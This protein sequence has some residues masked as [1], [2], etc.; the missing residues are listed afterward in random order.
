M[1]CRRYS[2]DDRDYSSFGC[3]RAVCHVREPLCQACI[4]ACQASGIPR[5]S[6][7]WLGR[8]KSLQILRVNL[9]E[10][11]YRIPAQTGQACRVNYLVEK[12]GKSMDDAEIFRP[13]RRWLA[14]CL[15][16]DGAFADS[17]HAIQ[18]ILD[19]AAKREWKQNP[20]GMR[21]I[22]EVFEPGQ[23]PNKS[24]LEL[25]FD[26][27][28]DN[29]LTRTYSLGFRSRQAMPGIPSPSRTVCLALLQPVGGQPSLW[30]R[31]WFL[32]IRRREWKRGYWGESATWRRGPIQ[33]GQ[34]N[35]VIHKYRE[36]L[37]VWR[38]PLG[39]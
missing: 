18:K 10:F 22:V 6:V 1:R 36:Q 26:D 27:E 34:L 9:H 32:R 39:R 4:A 2:A 30:R 11:L 21:F 17:E 24:S 25:V 33:P 28:A 12:H 13:V 15:L 37:S 20:A 5:L 3:D 38:Q 7:P 35:E 23:K 14:E 29:N 8:R 19:K 16:V 31:S